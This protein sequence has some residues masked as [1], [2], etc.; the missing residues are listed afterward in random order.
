LTLYWTGHNY[1][2]NLIDIILNRPQS[3]YK[4]DRHY[5]EQAKITKQIW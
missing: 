4:F 1:N 3:Q 5:I 2:A